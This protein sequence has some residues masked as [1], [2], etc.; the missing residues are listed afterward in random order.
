MT[1]PVVGNPVRLANN[2]KRN[3]ALTQANNTRVKQAVGKIIQDKGPDLS[4]IGLEIELKKRMPQKVLDRASRQVHILGSGDP[5]QEYQG[6]AAIE[7]AKQ[8]FIAI[9]RAMS[10]LV[11]KTTKH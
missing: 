9:P 7:S 11:A 6:R 10:G 2:V 5:V 8:A 1:L 4:I 3:I